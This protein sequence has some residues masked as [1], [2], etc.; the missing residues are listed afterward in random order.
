MKGATVLSTDP[1][2]VGKFGQRLREISLEYDFT[3][4]IRELQVH[5]PGTGLGFYFA[6]MWP[7]DEI[8]FT[9]PP[10]YPEPGVPMPD[11]ATVHGY[12]AHCRSEEFFAWMVSE[13]ARMT[14]HPVWVLDQ[15][16]VL[17]D[18]RNVDPSRVHL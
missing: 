9:E 5:E 4:E 17:W 10:H 6:P 8:C 2:L 12:G 16:N 14:E 13:V 7:G 15:G 11:F 3:R 18:A 1:E